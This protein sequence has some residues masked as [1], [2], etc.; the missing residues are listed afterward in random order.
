M[1]NV[2]NSKCPVCG[3]PSDLKYHPF[4]SKHCADIDLGHWLKGDY[5]MHTDEIPE[6]E[7]FP[8]E[9]DDE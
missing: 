4:C 6:K 5:V 1:L 3:L 2:K 8:L 7:T 9:K